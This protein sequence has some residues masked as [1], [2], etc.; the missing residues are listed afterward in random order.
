MNKRLRKFLCLLAAA[1][2]S[3]AVLARFF[4]QKD[5]F[6]HLSQDKNLSITEFRLFGNVALQPH[7]VLLTQPETLDYLTQA[8][9]NATNE[10][11][12]GSGCHAE[13]RLSDG[14]SYTTYV[15]VPKDGG[16]LEIG[17]DQGSFKDPIWQ[18]VRLKSPVPD[19]LAAAL[20]EMTNGKWQDKT[21]WDGL[22]GS[23][24]PFRSQ[25]VFPNAW[26]DTQAVPP[27]ISTTNS[28]LSE[29]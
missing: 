22:N 13:I 6:V 14:T 28:P 29:R 17:I 15:M 1:V 4:A 9:R 24:G 11:I 25:P 5:V 16:W 23:T 19:E 26:P 18:S 21:D 12:S 7:S 2:I 8:F 20:K 27:S 3:I 10:S